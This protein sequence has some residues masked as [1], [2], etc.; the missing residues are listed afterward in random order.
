[1]TKRRAPALCI[2]TTGVLL[3]VAGV[4]RAQQAC[5]HDADESRAEQARRQSALGAARFINTVQAMMRRKDG[6]Y[7]PLSDFGTSPIARELKTSKV[8]D[9]DKS[10]IL[11]GFEARLT[12][13]GKTY[14]FLITDKTD[15]CRFAYFSDS[16]GVIYEGRV[17]R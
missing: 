13:D 5:L 8:Y 16:Q 12:T 17:I 3:L 4:A 1:M 2:L 14:S 10:E 15:P 7:K 11:P 6:A 9:F